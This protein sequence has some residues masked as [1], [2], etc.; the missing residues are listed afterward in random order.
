M[1]SF[2][3]TIPSRFAAVVATRP[4]AVAIEDKRLVRYAELAQQAA[5]VAAQLP[6]IGSAPG[7]VAILADDRATAIASMLGTACSGH[8]YVPLD[9]GDPDARLRLIIEDAAPAVIVVE[10]ALADRARA[11]VDRM[12]PVLIVD[13]GSV[14]ATDGMHLR[15]PASPDSLVFVQ[16]TSG[17]S[18]RPKGVR[19]THRNLLFY[20]DAY[21]R[22]LGM[23]PDDRLSLLYT[24]SFSASNMDIYGGLLRGAT[25][26]PR[27]LRREGVRGLGPWLLDRK[28]TILHT[29]PTVLR[30]LT[31]SLEA[32]QSFPDLRA[33]DLGGEA[34]FAEDIRRFVPHV[35]RDCL[36]VNHLAATEI[37]VISQFAIRADAPLPQGILPA[38]RSPEGVQVTILT[39]TGEPASP[40]DSGRI[41]IDSAHLSPGYWQRPELDLAFTVLPDKPGWR[42]FLTE[43]RGSI[44]ADGLLHFTGRGGARV[45][46]R[47]HSVDLHEIEAALLACENV[48]ESAVTAEDSAGRE[49]ERIVAFVVLGPASGTTATDLHQQLA[50]RLPA[51]MLPS[52]YAF[53]DALPRTDTGKID[54]RGVAALA[55][56]VVP[57]RP[58]YLPPE[59]EYE[60]R[61]A[62]IFA[63]VLQ[64]ESIGRADDFFLLG[65]DSL[66][67]V[68]LQLALRAAFGRD[69]PDLIEHSTVARCAA[70][71]REGIATGS[72]SPMPLLVPL[73]TRGSRPPLYLVHG[74]LGQAFISPAFAAL[75]DDDQPLFAIQARGLD[76]LAPPART[77]DEMAADYV[78]AI[79]AH[80]PNGP[81]LLGALCAG[82]YVAM[83]M[84]EKLTAAGCQVQPL[85]LFDPPEPWSSAPVG[86]DQVERQI[87]YRHAQKRIAAPVG[88]PR[89]LRAAVD[90]AQ[91]FER[92]VRRHSPA[93][94]QQGTF[95]LMSRQRLRDH[96]TAPLLSRV[97]G[98]SLEC[99]TVGEA[100]RDVLDPA[101]SEF[102]SAVGRCLTRIRDGGLP[103]NNLSSIDTPHE[104]FLLRCR[105]GWRRLRRR[106]GL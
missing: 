61:V 85:L 63:Q 34:F 43:D 1:S 39:D 38:G 29:V 94:F 86:S 88:D 71:V 69:L 55:P 27:D 84:A 73:R 78:A 15:S 79:R 49:V 95:V 53:R 47:G 30:E 31:R 93:R 76:G 3:D 45:K 23:R 16:Y 6:S 77:I 96:W 66:R 81:Y 48:S 103:E 19:Q 74:R 41:A 54:R 105:R 89:L 40:G 58:D 67:A 65:G 68:E 52:A 32:T 44:D 104:S 18:G 14:E 33:V 100:H 51:Y 17:S 35:R 13:D 21:A 42:R 37:S 82:S 92:A 9:A 83:A 106:Y 4:D 50:R 75:F 102:Q 22:T 8:A 80:Q 59:D 46:I 91:A 90:V 87:R 28:I 26:C 12:C 20:S 62:L 57:S 64:C 11:L 101:N 10:P 2:H 60:Q 5:C 56:E 25:L 70:R 97:F 24:L 36:F 99:I 72:A 7:R 98:D